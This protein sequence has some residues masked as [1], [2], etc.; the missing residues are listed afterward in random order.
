MTAQPVAPVFQ[1]IIGQPAAVRLLAASVASPL[2]AYLFIGP[3]GTGREEAAVCFAAALFCPQGGCGVCAVCRE[4]LAR[5]HPDLVVVERE[6]AAISVPQAAE[7]ARLALR[8][9]RAAPY[10]VLVLVE[11]HL[12]GQA[13]PTLLK[14]IEEPPPST[15]IIVTAESVPPDFVTIASRCARV[16]FRPLGESDLVEALVQDSVDRQT[17]EAVAK[18]AHG[19][20]DR[21]RLLVDDA[22]FAARIARWRELP[23]RL[24]GTGA[25]AA[26]LAAELVAGANEP[27]EVVKARQAAAAQERAATAKAT[28]ER[29]LP[30][31]ELE[32]RERRE[33]R[34]ARTDELRA[35]LATL[36]AT[37]C[38]RLGASAPVARAA[39]RAIELIDE[40]GRRLTLNVNESLLL[41]WLTLELDRLA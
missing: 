16:E 38:E 18:A 14:T 21:A 19:R 26:R 30:A 41:E 5:R 20:L 35:G 15:V 24:D 17:A 11:F 13:A 4:T 31:R 2:H 23:T 32:A 8:T 25:T 37:Y 29:P 28:G 1:R 40:A 10:Q 12:L 9:P 39:V 36:Q 7:V 3:P 22:G 27:V 34:R 33:Q 6:G